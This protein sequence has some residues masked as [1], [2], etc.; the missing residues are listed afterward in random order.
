MGKGEIITGRAVLK[1][2]AISPVALRPFAG[3]TIDQTA[4]RIW[5]L[6]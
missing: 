4:N 1:P 5:G 6:P 2:A 3:L